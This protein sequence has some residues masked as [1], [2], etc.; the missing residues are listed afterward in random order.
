M[1]DTNRLVFGVLGPLEVW[2]GTDQLTP[3]APKQ[4]AVLAVLLLN[5]NS[6]V[7]SD[8]LIDE[9]WG[10][11]PPASAQA[12]LQV[13]VSQLRR[14]LHSTHRESGSNELIVTRPPGYIVR[15]APDQLD[16]HR[17][18]RLVAEGAQ[19][20]TE[21]RAQDAAERLRQALGLWRG[22]PLADLQFEAF[23]HVPAA[24]LE[25]LRLA[26][27]EKRIEADL[28]CGRHA[29]LV[30]ELQELCAE[31]RL[32]EGFAAQLML[33]LY[34]SGRQAD[35]LAVYQRTRKTLVDELGI[36]PRPALQRLERDIL[37]HDPSLD[38]AAEPEGLPSGMVTLVFTDIEDS[39]QLL[40]NLGEGYAAL[41]A[42]YRRIV[43]E[44][45][46]ARRGHEV[47][48]QGDGFFFAFRGVRDAA[49]AAV[50][51]L[52][53]IEA[54]AWPEDEEVH[55]RIGV[56]TG[57]PSVADGGYV[58]VD[59]H[60]AARIAGAA[61][62][63]QILL[64]HKSA[65]ALSEDGLPDLELRELGSH[66]L[67]GLEKPENLI[68]LTA[69]GLRTDFPPPR[70]SAVGGPPPARRRAVL[71]LSD[72]AERLDDALAIA[73]QL[74]LG[75]HPHELVL[76]QLLDPAEGDRLGDVAASLGELRQELEQQG[77]TA[78][79]AVFTSSAYDEDVVRLASRSEIDLLLTPAS[80][81]ILS[82]GAIDDTL[83]SLLRHVLCDVAVLVRN[84]RDGASGRE[85][86]ILVPFGA[87]EHDWAAL[88][89]AAWLAGASNR[90]LEL[91][92]AT[93]ETEPGTRD[94]SRL[95]ADA[96]LLIQRASGVAP[97]PRLVAP[98]H[99]GVVHAA[100][101]GGLL[102]LGLS[103]R[104]ADEGLGM[105]RW[106]IARSASA[107]VLFVRRGLRPGGL[108]PAASATRF[109][110]SVT[111]GA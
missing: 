81:E 64:S 34:R 52:R 108:A 96:G 56:H 103:E 54:E 53:A 5:A 14:Q 110:W 26:A 29:E 44:S 20:L 50:E 17:F 45:F 61:H 24:R 41:L 98:G 99:E 107:P 6:V 72:G 105:T 106:A 66:A 79:V 76:A 12:A 8:R 93:A 49:E 15:I 1:D 74:A 32:Q 22:P 111:A 38:L 19:A 73:E 71:V 62:G 27:V 88:E 10:E 63:G 75:E 47:D 7:S 104:W 97:V 60:R 36:D 25:E 3:S 95:L 59:V 57:V 102:V 86:P 87:G 37:V 101:G 9:L 28:A 33:A 16:L 42:A 58:G 2:R 4:R 48:R 90:R 30:G 69:P 89:L 91:L 51:C 109:G 35:A 46:G 40:Q 68:Q 94:A 11:D 13:H 78:R 83:A 43:R 77:G 39:T 21:G 18:E 80:S 65:A 70:T 31:H 92:G 82:E 23:P 85:G 100:A 55:V 84:R 67:R